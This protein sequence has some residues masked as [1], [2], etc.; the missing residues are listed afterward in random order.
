MDSCLPFDMSCEHVLQPSPG[1]EGPQ[2]DVTCSNGLDD[3]CDGRSDW[4]DEDCGHVPSCAGV[5][6]GYDYCNTI[7]CGDCQDGETCIPWR[8]CMRGTWLEVFPE[9]GGYTMGSPQQ[10]PGRA[11]G[12]L[13]HTVE[14]THPFEI[15]STEMTQE[16]YEEIF[17]GDPSENWVCEPDCPVENLTW[18]EAAEFC[19]S[20]SAMYRYDPC[21]V[22]V[23]GPDYAYELDAAYG[24]PYDCPGYRLPTEA[25]WE[26]AARAG[27]IESTYNGEI[28]A[29]HLGCEQPNAT[30]DPIA[31]FCGN[32]STT[33]TVGQKQGN[34]WG[35]YDML[36]NVAEW[37][38]DRYTDYA[39][40][41]QTDPVGT[42]GSLF[43]VRGGSFG[44]PA[45][46][47]RAAARCTREYLERSPRVGFRCARTLPSR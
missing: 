1:A 19:N 28:D 47:C 30:L 15:W 36:G 13:P 10:E 23:E 18:H 20:L 33:G 41:P 42:G 25:E 12:E 8:R 31:R 45:S 22:R 26:Y 24:T 6:C 7:W 37:C 2:Q 40:L 3:D 35:L 34:A 9:P 16:F 14:L 4:C 39:Q 5:E 44:D 29:G 17:W 32:S 21:Y 46:S 11:P 38:H 27:A 43:V